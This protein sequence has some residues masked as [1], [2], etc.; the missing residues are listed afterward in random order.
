M[1]VTDGSGGMSR[2]NRLVAGFCW[3]S[4]DPDDAGLLEPGREGRDWSMLWNAGEGVGL[5]G[6]GRAPRRADEVGCV[7]TAQGFEYDYVGVIFGTV[8]FLSS[9]FEPQRLLRRRVCGTRSARCRR[10]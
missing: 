10:R 8:T 1:P 7:Y 2:E 6:P 4:S 9:Y 5:P 3:P